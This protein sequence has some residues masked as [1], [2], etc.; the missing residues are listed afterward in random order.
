M[1]DF[2]ISL[3]F[4]ISLESIQASDLGQ[5]GINEYKDLCLY[6]TQNSKLYMQNS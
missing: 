5:F 3:V 4:N 2:F 6:C 1:L